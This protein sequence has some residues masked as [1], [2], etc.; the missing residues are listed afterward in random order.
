MAVGL[1]VSVR[2]SV[3]VGELRTGRRLVA[4]PYVGGSWS[5]A[6]G[7]AGDITVKLPT[8]AAEYQ[9]LTPVLTGG[10]WPSLDVY[11][12]ED[13]FPRAVVTRWVP[14]SSPR[15][16]IRGATEPTRTFL[17]VMAGDRVVEAGP[18]WSRTEG[19]DGTLE[20]RALGLRSLWDHRLVLNHLTNMQQAG[21]IAS[22]S[23]SYSGLSLGT[24]AKRLVQEAQAHT[25]G[26]LPVVFPADESGTST[27]TYP[28]FEL[29]TVGQ[30][31]SELSEVDGG[32]EIEFQPRLTAD[33]TGVEWV[34]RIGTTARPQLW[35]SGLDWMVDTSVPRGNLGGLS[36]KED[37]SATVNRAFAK[38]AGTDEATVISVPS[39]DA[40]RLAAGYPLLESR[41]SVGG[42]GGTY[43]DNVTRHAAGDLAANVRPWQTW[44]LK[45]PVDARVGAARPGDWWSIRVGEGRV[46]VEP[47]MYRSRM[48]S[49]SGSL[50]STFA[51]VTLVPTE[52]D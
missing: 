25:G 47:G 17:A 40:A 46:L 9:R 52:V 33:R 19:D 16:D 14:G 26:S 41:G 42:D 13:T 4:L 44:S 27:R 21:A 48:Q 29:A 22:S 45:V 15:G 35:Q 18:I 1:V 32:P 38:G 23:L 24:I 39:T 37:A 8:R 6:A 7:S 2:Y 34:M 20:L 30:R 49:M 11:P 31:L 10:L 51:D 12:S 36:I 50:D 28:G 3:L 43:Q 5:I